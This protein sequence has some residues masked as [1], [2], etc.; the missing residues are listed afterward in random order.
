MFDMPIFR[1]SSFSSSCTVFTGIRIGW[2]GIWE[3]RNMGEVEEGQYPFNTSWY[4]DKEKT[5][6]SLWN[7]SFSIPTYHLNIFC[8]FGSNVKQCYHIY[9]YLLSS[10]GSRHDFYLQ[11]LALLASLW[12]TFKK[13]KRNLNIL[14]KH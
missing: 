6:M 5:G 4:L 14:S 10:I 9:W 3:Y 1:I 2:S 13:E 8:L 12:K 11:K 7:H